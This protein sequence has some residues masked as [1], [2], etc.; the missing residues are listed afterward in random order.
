MKKILIVLSILILT[1][2]F[3][4]SGYVTRSCKKFESAG[5]LKTESIYTFTFKNDVISDINV[6]YKYED[7]NTLTIDSIKTSIGGQNKFLDLNYEILTDESSKYEI[8]Y[9]IDLESDKQIL[10][11]FM[12]KSKRSDLV[13]KL[14]TEG[15]ECE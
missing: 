1:G 15:Y 10:D 7:T 2:C 12:I 14:K 6:L 5:S 4:N 11:K 8:K 9:N 3:E 13:N